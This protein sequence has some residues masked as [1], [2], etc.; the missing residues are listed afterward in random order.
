MN[1]NVILAREGLSLKNT[2]WTVSW[3]EKEK[4]MEILNNSLI[5]PQEEF[6]KYAFID[7]VQQKI[8]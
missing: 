6:G 3:S 5:I 8:F 1:Y 2:E 7:N 4:T